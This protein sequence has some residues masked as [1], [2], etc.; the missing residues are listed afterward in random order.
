MMLCSLL[1]TIHLLQYFSHSS[2]IFTVHKYTRVYSFVFILTNANAVKTLLLH[3]E[4]RSSQE[5]VAMV[6]EAAR[7]ICISLLFY[8]CF[9]TII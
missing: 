2:Q 9:K 3:Q 1:P 6:T 8:V 7:Q 5:P 4:M